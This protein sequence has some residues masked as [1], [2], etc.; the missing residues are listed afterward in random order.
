M[1]TIKNTTRQPVVVPLPRGKKLHLGPLQ[2]GEIADGAEEHPPL[3]K[4]I[5][6]GDI[7]V[8]GD[9]SHGHG[10]RPADD[11]A[12]VETHGHQQGTVGHHRGER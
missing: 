5:E 3:V 9:G 2:T 6:L 11:D 8:L 12:R 4:M 10:P 7:E 1:K